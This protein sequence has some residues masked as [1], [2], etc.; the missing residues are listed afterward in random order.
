MWSGR[1]SEA[2]STSRF[3]LRHISHPAPSQATGGE[4]AFPFARV[5]RA[6]DSARL[7]GL[8]NRRPAFERIGFHHPLPQQ[9]SRNA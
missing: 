3:S 8:I 5:C 2:R 4:V 1:T 7:L 9:R 6:Y